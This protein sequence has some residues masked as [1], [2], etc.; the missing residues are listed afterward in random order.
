LAKLD[1]Y[2]AFISPG[3]LRRIQSLMTV[4]R[5]RFLLGSLASLLLNIVAAD[6]GWA[7]PCDGEACPHGKHCVISSPGKPGHCV[8]NPRPPST[9]FVDW[10]NSGFEDG[11]AAAPI[12]TLPTALAVAA[13]QNTIKTI[14][15]RTGSYSLPARPISKPLTFR[16]ENGPVTIIGRQLQVAATY[17]YDNKRTGWNSNE[18]ILNSNI[19]K[20]SPF[21]SFPFGLLHT[22]PLDEKVSAQ[23]LV[24][25]NQDIAGVGNR[26]V[27]YVVT[28][29]NTVYAIDATSG[30]IL[31]SRSL[32]P[33][34]SNSL[35]GCGDNG[36]LQGITS[37][38]LIDTTKNGMYLIAY[39]MDSTDPAHPA[40]VHQLHL[41]DLS[42]LADKFSPVT[43]SASN[44]LTDGTPY[45][46]L[47][48]VTRQRAGLLANNGNIYAGFASH[49]D[50][51]Q[52]RSRGWLLGWNATTL[53]SLPANDLVNRVHTSSQYY[54]TSIW[55]SGFG[56]ASDIDGNLYAVT[57]NTD[58]GGHTFN[59]PN[60]LSESAIKISGD[61]TKVLGAFTPD[62]VDALD[63]DDKDFGS[64]GIMLLPD[65]QGPTPRLAVAAGK[66]GDMFL[67]NR[68]N[69]KK[70]AVYEIGPC[71]CGPS[72]FEGSDGVNRVV[73]S[74][75]GPIGSGRA[76]LRVWKLVTS[77]GATSLV[78]EFHTEI[79]SDDPDPNKEP[80]GFFTSVS[81]N[82]RDPNSVI[83][84]G[85]ARPVSSSAP[86]MLY[87]FDAKGNQLYKG[88]A[89]QWDVNGVAYSVPVVA[90][91]NV[92]VG[93]N[94]QLAI[95]GL[96]S[97]FHEIKPL[98]VAQSN[99][100]PAAVGVV[101][102]VEGSTIAL[103]KRDGTTITIDIS[104]ALASHMAV[105]IVVGKEI[106]VQGVL[107]GQGVLQA[108]SVSHG[109]SILE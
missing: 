68:D 102:A 47:S 66:D 31:T 12:Q 42:T 13:T 78:E 23:P 103:R 29:A 85:V 16:A 51:Y 105:P 100:R 79:M 14:V 99:L 59:F 62:N 40:P 11:T 4:T 38:P 106:A 98:A 50:F 72:Y 69:M 6:L 3:G 92:Y 80:T 45:S 65:Q 37:T 87:A 21:G 89:G 7:Q 91:G 95:F 41:I 104:K 53:A 67:L 28:E 84:W 64:G 35:F 97:V 90:N 19:L 60:N 2:A 32:G 70:I 20:S 39:T 76:I 36:P 43:I 88:P 18:I 10:Q 109:E 71:W 83:I 101:T 24:V 94:H 34:V 5:L 8:E 56:V 86:L 52:D 61:L 58:P 26:D 74:G 1:Q 33:A 9:I 54:L 30:A 77:G 108:E 49:C 15:I 22:V 17:H 75:G 27:V 93:S 44:T 46:F 73:S 55:M 81:S 57:G 96:G 107:N 63:H 25:P 82:L 48:R